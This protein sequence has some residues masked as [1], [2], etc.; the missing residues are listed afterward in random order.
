LD[1]EDRYA[2][3][4]LIQWWSQERL[5]EARVAVFGA[6]A[7]GNEVLKLLALLGVGHIVVVDFDTIDLSNLSRTVLFRESDI[8][9]SK[10]LTATSRVMELNPAVEVQAI[11]GDL[12]FDVGLGVLRAAD[13]AIGCLDSINARLALNRACLRAGIPWINGGIEDTI[14]QVSLFGQDSACFEC[15]MSPAMWEHRN[16][17]YSCSGLR[18]TGSPDRVPT[19]AIAASLAASLMVNEA[20]YLLHSDGA[21]KQGL[22]FGQQISALTLPYSLHVMEMLRNPHCTAHEYWSPVTVITETPAQLIPSEL[23]TKV[24]MPGGVVELGFDLLVEM[25]CTRCGQVEPV[26]KPVERCSAGLDRCTVC[27]ADTRMPEIVSWIDAESPLAGTSLAALAIPDHQVLA[28]KDGESQ[29][30]VQLSGEFKFAL[31]EEGGRR[32]RK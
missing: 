22:K 6:G 23:L 10:A 21:T 16:Q 17:R 25:R 20:L 3:H 11:E 14:A 27:A 19:T 8:G 12:E 31:Q 28:V 5:A 7:I 1:S 9:Q 13:L 2:R 29:R 18:R 24:G 15:G 4:R 32:E 30:Y 26:L